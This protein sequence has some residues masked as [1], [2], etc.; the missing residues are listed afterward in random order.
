M[1]IARVTPTWVQ[2]DQHQYLFLIDISDRQLTASQTPSTACSSA[3]QPIC[4]MHAI[5]TRVTL[6]MVQKEGGGGFNPLV[7]QAL[8][9]IRATPMLHIYVVVMEQ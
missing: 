7:A 1:L 4:V 9:G 2:L 5:G 3:G 8:Q 6:A